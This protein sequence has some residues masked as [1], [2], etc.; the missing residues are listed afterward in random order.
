MWRNLDLS[1]GRGRGSRVQFFPVVSQFFQSLTHKSTVLLKHLLKILLRCWEVAFIA[2]K[3]YSTIHFI[4]II[5]TFVIYI[6]YITIISSWL[7]FCIRT[8]MIAN[9]FCHVTCSWSNH[10]YTLRHK[11]PQDFLH[12]KIHSVQGILAREITSKSYFANPLLTL[13]GFN[14]I[15][16][17][18][19]GGGWLG[20]QT[21]K[22]EQLP[23]TS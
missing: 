22:V 14:L 3:Y 11:R 21:F 1:F 10:K 15:Y 17:G 13:A 9:S 6:S 18:G 20:P 2:K 23:T 5:F 4:N 7:T 8:Y 19:G 16:G 12:R